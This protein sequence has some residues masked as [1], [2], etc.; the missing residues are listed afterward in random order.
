VHAFNFAAPRTWSERVIFAVDD[1]EN[2][3]L[4]FGRLLEQPG[5]EYPYRLFANGGEMMDALLKVL[6]GASPPLACFIDIKMAGMS[7]FDVLR[8]IRCQDALDCVPVIMLSSSEDPH[9]LSEARDVGAQCYVG[10]FPSAAELRNIITEAQRYC[11]DHS[12]PAAFH[13]PCNLLLGTAA[14]V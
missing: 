5:L 13:L 3:R 11:A 14:R 12:A 8:W 9:K 2:D 4:L 10:K 1:D 6:R 7:G